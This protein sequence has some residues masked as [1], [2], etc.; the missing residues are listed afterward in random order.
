MERC[1]F[2]VST[3]NGNWTAVST[4]VWCMI[5]SLWLEMLLKML[6]YWPMWANPEHIFMSEGIK[7]LISFKLKIDSWKGNTGQKTTLDS[8]APLTV[9]LRA[10]PSSLSDLCFPRGQWTWHHFLLL[11]EALLG[12]KHFCTILKGEPNFNITIC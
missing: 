9:R 12:K 8:K 4:G 10:N 5:V 11:N 1:V 7:F 6:P 3:C 2:T